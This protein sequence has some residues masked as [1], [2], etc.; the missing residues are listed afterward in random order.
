M[1]IPM[2]PH[3]AE[4][5]QNTSTYPAIVA[6]ENNAT[7]SNKNIISNTCNLYKNI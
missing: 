1:A 5:F 2:Y 4:K 3:E 6:L 7:V